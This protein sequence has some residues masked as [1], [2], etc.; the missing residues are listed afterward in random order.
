MIER[1]ECTSLAKRRYIN[2]LPFLSPKRGRSPLPNFSAHVYCGQTAGCIKMALG[3]DVGL[4][5]GHIALDGHPGPL[6][7]R[8]GQMPSPI[9]GPFL[10]CGQTAGCIKMPVGME[11]GLSPSDFVLDGDRALLPKKGAEP[12]PPK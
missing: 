10:Y 9:F 8:G 3:L 4:G 5:P 7:K 6:L 2:T 1:F 12:P 11:V